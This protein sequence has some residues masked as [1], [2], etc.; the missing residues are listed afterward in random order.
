MGSKVDFFIIGTQKG[1]TTAIDRYLRQHPQ[2]Q[3]ARIKEV[4][5]FDNDKLSWSKPDHKRLH[6]QY[7]W[8]VPGVMRGEATPIYLYWPQSLLR[9]QA[10]N[11]EAKLIVSLRHPAYRAYS[12][13][14]MET[15]RE[16]ETLS[17][18]DAISPHGRE[19]VAQAPNGVHRVYSYIERSCYAPQIRVLLQLFSRS[20]IFFM[21]IDDLWSKPGK[22][23]A[24]VEQ[25]LGVEKAVSTAPDRSYVKA[26]SGALE[27]DRP[28]SSSD[29]AKLDD[30]FR[31]DI[32]ETAILTGLDLS[33]WLS[34][35]YSE[36]LKPSAAFS[37]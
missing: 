25:F 36:N 31:D 1:G 30:L 18:E 34:A 20:Q 19:R 22:A 3:M 5:H 32:K 27:D 10:Y 23:L 8:S 26:T 7:D 24:E 17:F 29:R 9:L 33:E 11:P 4:H 28:L 16:R 6:L 21:R 15:R 13:W 35:S 14:K 12:H 37:G 2:L